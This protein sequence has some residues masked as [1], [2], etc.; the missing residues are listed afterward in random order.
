MLSDDARHWIGIYG[1]FTLSTDVAAFPIM[2]LAKESG[3]IHRFIVEFVEQTAQRTRISPLLL[4]GENNHVVSAYEEWLGLERAEITTAGVGDD[5]DVE[6]NYEE[7]PPASLG[8]Y[9]LILSQAMFEHLLD[10]YRH[11]CDLFSLLEIDGSLIVLT[12][13]PGFPYHRYPV[14]CL[15]FYPDWF[16]EAAKRLRAEV[17]GRL[18]GED[19][20]LYQ[21]T[22]RGVGTSS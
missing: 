22:K 11:L 3:W 12:H 1:S 21:L 7:T 9:A 20:I 14:D 5:F 17:T 19:R 4:A 10:P 2:G 13:T 8:S 18:I 16:E 6:W 15:R